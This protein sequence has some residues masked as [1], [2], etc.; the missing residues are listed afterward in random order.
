M[1]AGLPNAW[2]LPRN[3]S[4]SSVQ[5]NPVQQNENAAK[6]PPETK[7]SKA[8]H[9]FAPALNHAHPRTDGRTSL[10][11]KLEA[12]RN[13]LDQAEAASSQL[14]LPS[15]LPMQSVP[16]N[17]VQGIPA[18]DYD[19]RPTMDG[20]QQMP[21]PDYDPR[22]TMDG[23]PFADNAAF[24]IHPDQPADFETGLGHLPEH[25]RI[26]GND[27]TYMI[28]SLPFLKWWTNKIAI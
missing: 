5:F 20:S 18:P 10:D 1:L 28:P 17:Q 21:P 9:S 7:G 23:Q 12:Q 27:D 11:V 26:T 25:A 22:A 13:K 8:L 6:S 2:S 14:R 19:P 4:V 16:E 15:L 24:P 3:S